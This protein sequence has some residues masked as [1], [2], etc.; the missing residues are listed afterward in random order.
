VEHDPTALNEI[1]TQTSRV[2]ARVTNQ[3]GVTVSPAFEKGVLSR[4]DLI[5]VASNRVLVIISVRSGLARTLLL[6]VDAEIPPARLEETRRLLNERLVGVTLG[7]LRKTAAER[8]RDTKGEPRLIKM[9]IESSDRLVTLQ[10]EDDL[11][12]GGTTNIMTQPEFRDIKHLSGLMQIIED[13]SHLLDWIQASEEGEGIVITIGHEFDD[14]DLARCSLV[15]STYRVGHV[16]G[17]IGIL[18]PTRM[19]YSKLVSVVEYTSN[20]LTEVLSR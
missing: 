10:E 7:E 19:P 18:G 3:L 20:V 11:H 2:L 15:T 6:E 9:F 14:L 17:T 5:Q 16:K 4:L 1:L 13:R 12:V 8:L